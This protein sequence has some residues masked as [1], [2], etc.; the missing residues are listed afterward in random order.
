MLVNFAKMMSSLNQTPIAKFIP[1]N[2]TRFKLHTFQKRSEH[3]DLETF[4]ILIVPTL[5]TSTNTFRS[6]AQCRDSTINILSPKQRHKVHRERLRRRFKLIR[7]FRTNGD[8]HY[9][10]SQAP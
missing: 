2:L 7:R 4:Q 6:P 5:P 9:I 3:L 10:A 1:A 8:R